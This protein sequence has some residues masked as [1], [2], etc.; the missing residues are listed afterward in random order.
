VHFTSFRLSD[1]VDVVAAVE[2]HVF[3]VGTVAIV[4]VVVNVSPL[5]VGNVVV[6]VGDIRRFCVG[7]TTVAGSIMRVVVARTAYLL[8]LHS[9]TVCTRTETTTYYVNDVI[10][11]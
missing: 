8:S 9:D 5:N 3:Y 1:A 6:V 10:P 11:F 7:M 2:N 4:G